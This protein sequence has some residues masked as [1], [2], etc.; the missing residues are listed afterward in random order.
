VKR[1]KWLIVPDVLPLLIIFAVLT[2]IVYFL[3]GRKVALVPLIFLLFI[4]YFFRNPSRKTIAQSN[5]I[6]SPADGVI[7]AVEKVEEK[8]YLHRSAIKVSIFL[9]IFNV[10]VNRVPIAGVIDY[11]C[12]HPGKFIPAFKSHAS[13][14]NERNYIGIKSEDNPGWAVLVV[15][16]TGFIARRIVCWIKVGERLGQ[17]DLLGMIKF[18][19]CTELYLPSDSTVLVEKGQKV[20]GGETII[21]RFAENE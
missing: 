12:Y 14:L 7:L 16:I 9:N 10:H 19:S 11:L 5:E 2:I 13:Q 21:G 8:N 1:D 20:R 17:G 4:L 3:G 6:V 15:Q 18:G